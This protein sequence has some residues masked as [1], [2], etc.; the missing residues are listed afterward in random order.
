MRWEYRCTSI[1]NNYEEEL[2]KYGIAGWE[3]ITCQIEKTVYHCIFKRPL[4]S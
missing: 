4:Q 3:L 2:D 1:S